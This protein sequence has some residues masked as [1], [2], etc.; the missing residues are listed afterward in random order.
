[1][2]FGARVAPPLNGEPLGKGQWVTCADF[3]LPMAKA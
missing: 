1:M 3:P 2:G